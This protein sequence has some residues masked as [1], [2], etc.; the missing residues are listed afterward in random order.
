MTAVDTSSLLYTLMD[1]GLLNCTVEGCPLPASQPWIVSGQ[2]IQTCCWWHDYDWRHD[3]G[4]RIYDE[5]DMDESGQPHDKPMFVCPARPWSWSEAAYGD[6]LV[7]Q[8]AD[9]YE[10]QATASADHRRRA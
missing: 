7:A 8:M 5:A 1:A 10:Q 6:L 4:T 2:G 9:E 3:V